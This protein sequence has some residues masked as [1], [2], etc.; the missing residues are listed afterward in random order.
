M[1]VSVSL[2]LRL[3][4]FGMI[5]RVSVSRSR[6]RDRVGSRESCDSIGI[7]QVVSSCPRIVRFPE[8]SCFSDSRDWR[9]GAGRMRRRRSGLDNSGSRG[10]GH[11]RRSHDLLLLAHRSHP[12]LRSNI[13][14]DSLQKT[15]KEP[16]VDLRCMTF[17]DGDF[18]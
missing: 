15:F 2:R 10:R 14:T 1:S 18:G 7:V 17:V 9:N 8:W 3:R 16:S 4:K 6:D 12:L 13:T 5:A 11:G